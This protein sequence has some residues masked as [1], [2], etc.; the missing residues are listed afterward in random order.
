VP[1]QLDRQPRVA[2]AEP[3]AIVFVELAD[4]VVV[5]ADLLGCSEERRPDAEYERCSDPADD[6]HAEAGPEVHGLSVGRG[7][8]AWSDAPRVE[9]NEAAISRSCEPEP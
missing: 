5:S 2:V 8:D 3:A 1:F 6:L 9:V 7:S 4:A